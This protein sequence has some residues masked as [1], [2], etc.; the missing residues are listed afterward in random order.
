MIIFFCPKTLGR[1]QVAPGN[2]WASLCRRF[3]DWYDT[4]RHDTRRLWRLAVLSWVLC[5]MSPFTMTEWHDIRHVF[6]FFFAFF[7]FLHSWDDT[8]KMPSWVLHD[9]DPVASLRRRIH[10]FYPTVLPGVQ[11]IRLVAFLAVVSS[12]SFGD[13]PQKRSWLIVKSVSKLKSLLILWLFL[14]LC[15]TR[16]YPTTNRPKLFW[17]R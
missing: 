16:G 8:Q 10:F 5:N 3:E 12:C 11:K 9:F 15:W 13:S 6:V 2:L 1:V 17:S 4:I 7:I 14:W